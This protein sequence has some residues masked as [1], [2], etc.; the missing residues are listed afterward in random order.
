MVWHNKIEIQ[1]LNLVVIL[2]VTSHKGIHRYIHLSIL[3]IC[4]FNNVAHTL[5][6]IVIHTSF[7]DNTLQ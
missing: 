5:I 3:N 2:S 7:Q 4:R 6:V 1:Q